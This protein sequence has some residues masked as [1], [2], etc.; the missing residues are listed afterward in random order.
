MIYAMMRVDVTREFM[1]LFPCIAGH[2]ALLAAKSESDVIA[3]AA[4]LS[5]VMSDLDGALASQQGYLL[6]SWI[7]TYW[8]G[9]GPEF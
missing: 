5:E 9:R 4:L 7:G 3:A 2:D 1:V 6:G 8:R